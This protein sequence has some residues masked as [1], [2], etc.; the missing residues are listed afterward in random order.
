MGFAVDWVKQLLLEVRGS[1]MILHNLYYAALVAPPVC[2]INMSA[3]RILH[4]QLLIGTRGTPCFCISTFLSQTTVT[5]TSRNTI[6]LHIYIPIVNDGNQSSEERHTA[7]YLHSHRVQQYPAY[8]IRES[9]EPQFEDWT[10]RRPPRVT[11][12]SGSKEILRCQ[13]A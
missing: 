12:F 2:Y 7:A 9:A 10:W 4:D 3:Q 1:H 13:E 11:E 8:S 5:A 6:L